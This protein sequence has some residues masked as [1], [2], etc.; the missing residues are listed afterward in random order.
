M[1]KKILVSKSILNDIDVYKF[2]RYD[3]KS[4]TFQ[5]MTTDVK[6]WLELNNLIC[7]NPKYSELYLTKEEFWY[8]R[9]PKDGVLCWV[10]KKEFNNREL[11]IVI[12]VVNIN[13]DP[14]VKFVTK[15][16]VHENAIPFSEEDTK[17]YIMNFN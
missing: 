8:D 6:V 10:W 12:D 13:D 9:I 5:F 3:K 4:D 11:K 2:Y 1:R 14:A 17:R 15:C 7:I 16:G